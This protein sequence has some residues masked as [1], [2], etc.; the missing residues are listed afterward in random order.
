MPFFTKKGSGE[1]RTKASGV[2]TPVSLVARNCSDDQ[3]MFTGRDSAIRQWQGSESYAGGDVR[4]KKQADQRRKRLIERTSPAG[5]AVWKRSCQTAE[6]G[7]D[8]LQYF[9]A[10]PPKEDQSWPN[11]PGKKQK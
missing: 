2:L 6:E 9:E 8:A 11:G 1:P 7:E 3:R 10:M 5:G 4:F